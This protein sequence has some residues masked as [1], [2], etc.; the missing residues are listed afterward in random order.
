MKIIRVNHR[1]AQAAILCLLYLCAITGHAAESSDKKV[2]ALYEQAVIVFDQI[3]QEH[4]RTAQ[5]NGINLHY[6]DFGSKDGMPL[7]WAHGG[8]GTRYGVLNVKD[9][10]VAAG[11]RVISVDYRGHGKTTN[12][13]ESTSIYDMAD[14]LAALMDHLHLSTAVMGGWSYGGWLTTAFYDEYPE[15]TLGLLLEDGGS[16]NRQE[17]IDRNPISAEEVSATKKASAERKVYLSKFAAFQ[18]LVASQVDKK[19]PVQAVYMLSSCVERAEGQWVNHAQLTELIDM[20]AF[21]LKQPSRQSLAL[22]SKIA[23]QPEVIFRHLHVPMH[24]L[25]AVSENDSIPVSDLNQK[26]KEQHPDLIVHEI[27]GDTGHNI[28]FQRPERFIESAKALLRRVKAGS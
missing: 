28:H 13:D 24:I 12:A 21:E 10:L 3:E 27:Y 11:Y 1:L 4:G 14:D 5:V 9:G 26:L 2:K 22:G 7:I 19:S 25:D 8:G 23:M 16:F 15:R 20:S 17:L 6:L 18:A